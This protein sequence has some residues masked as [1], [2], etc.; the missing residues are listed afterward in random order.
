MN[1]IGGYFEL[2]DRENGSFL[3]NGGILLNTGRNALEH[4]LRNLPDIKSVLLPY[5]TCEAVIEPIR[6]Y[7]IP[8]SYYHIDSNLEV[9][10]DIELEEGQFIIVNDYFGIKDSYVIRQYERFGGQLI[11]DCAQA[12]FFEPLPGMKAFYSCRKFVGVADGGI[13]YGIKDT[14]D[15]DYEVDDSADHCSHLFIRKE[16]GAEAGFSAYQ[17]NERKLCNQCIRRMSSFTKDILDNIDYSRIIARRRA[18]YEYLAEQLSGINAINLPELKTFV[19]PMVYPFIDRRGV[20]KREQLIDN[21]I[22]VAKYWP[23]VSDTSSFISESRLAEVLLPLPVDQRY[24]Q[25][26]M[27]RIVSIII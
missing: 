1:P 17:E 10:D 24:G 5:Y 3:R 27:E 6:R 9:A 22:F 14:C 2:A 20:V 15:Q 4:I 19:C 16:L 12:F 11:A 23:N 7:G 18:N 26:E 8:Y 13:A 25:E 21:K